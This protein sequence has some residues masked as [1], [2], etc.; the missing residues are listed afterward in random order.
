MKSKQNWDILFTNKSINNAIGVLLNLLKPTTG[1]T[2]NN[3][4]THPRKSEVEVQ[5]PRMDNNN[6]NNSRPRVNNNT[7]NDVRPPRVN[8]N[9]NNDVQPP[10]CLIIR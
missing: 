4:A 2:A 8:N 3:T 10:R 9:T 6:N 1:A 7:N 5:R